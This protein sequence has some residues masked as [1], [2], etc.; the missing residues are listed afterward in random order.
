[1]RSV[2]VVFPASMCAMIPIFRT[3]S[4]AMLV[5]TATVSSPLPA[6]V[7]EGLVGLRHPVHVVLAL[8]RAALF[9]ERVE[10]LAG[11][12][13]GH[14]LLAP[15]AREGDEPADRQRTAAALRHLD[16]HLVVRTAD[17][18]ALDLEHGRHRLDRLL[19]HLEGWAS[20]ALA[21][22]GQRVVDDLLGDR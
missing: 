17:T 1:M 21:D 11:Q 4:R 8:E 15:V 5:A 2:V 6:V 3:R 10:D 20:R 16:G 22:H 19:E 13:R 9:V 12:L 7:R 18:P 14:P